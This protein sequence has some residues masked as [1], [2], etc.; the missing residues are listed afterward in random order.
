MST[1]GNTGRSLAATTAGSFS[2][3]RLSLLSHAPG[4]PRWTFGKESRFGPAA[5]LTAGAHADSGPPSPKPGPASRR[6]RS[7]E[8]GGGEEEEGAGTPRGTPLASEGGY[9]TEGS[10][11]WRKEQPGWRMDTTLDRFI[12]PPGFRSRT[13][14]PPAIAYAPAVILGEGTNPAFHRAPHFSFGGGASRTV[15]KRKE[16][17]GGRTHAQTAA[18]RQRTLEL[19][20]ERKEKRKTVLARNFGSAPRLAVKGG[21]LEMPFSP[22][23]AA[24]ELPRDGDPDAEWVQA[25]KVPWGKRTG[26]RGTIN[27]RSATDAGPGEHSAAH[28]FTGASKPSPIFGHRPHTKAPAVVPG[29]G[30]YPGVVLTRGGKPCTIG[31]GHRGSIADELVGRSPGPARYEVEDGRIQRQTFHATF[32]NVERRHFTE[33]VDP[34]EPP[35]PGAHKVRRD[36]ASDAT[37]VGLPKSEKMKTVPGMLPPWSPLPGAHSPKLPTKGRDSGKTMGMPLPLPA[38][39]PQKTPGPTDYNTDSLLVRDR[40]PEFASMAGRTAERRSEFDLSNS[41]QQADD[42]IQRVAAAVDKEMEAQGRGVKQRDEYAFVPGGPSI[43]MAGRPRQLSWEAPEFRLGAGTMYG[44]TSSLGR[45]CPQDRQR[46]QRK[47]EAG[48]EQATTSDAA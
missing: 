1:K 16:D 47:V 20:A 44:T 42:Q 6:S 12:D 39:Q 37:N 25:S 7:E 46:P 35:G 27:D 13:A 38:P 48:G 41:A 34:D 14:Y 26:P 19:I 23:P 15:E 33:D 8:A 28:P 21:A 40:A 36:F 17:E 3:T 5:S 9:A 32:G 24:Y 45:R 11:L 30:A 29:P 43:S 10:H 2:E 18:A 31:R 22:G 4:L